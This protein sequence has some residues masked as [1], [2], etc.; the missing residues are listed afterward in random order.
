VL[1]DACEV[2][3]ADPAVQSERH[4]TRLKALLDTTE[5]GRWQSLRNPPDQARFVVAAALLRL[6]VGA[7]LQVPPTAVEVDRTCDQCGRPHG[8]PRIHGSDLHVSISHAGDRV[9]VAL[10]R[11]GPVGVDVEQI[12]DLDPWQLGQVVLGPGETVRDVADFFV[13]W[14]RK[15]SVV[16]AV[17]DGLR[18]PLP[19]VLLGPPDQPP[20][21]QGYPGRPDL[22]AWM[23]DLAPG[24]GYAGAL[25]V[26][27]STPPRVRQRWADQL[28]NAA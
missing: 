3:W 10:T 22:V 25:T 19:E 20:R 9:A 12:V 24:D 28:L 21:L 1:P 5:R 14:C 2:W 6:A 26:L 13:T 27:T 7:R 16:K 15:E 23:G 17:G 8:R 18:A 4:L 11:L